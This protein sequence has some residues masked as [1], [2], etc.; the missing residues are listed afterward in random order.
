MRND[1]SAKKNECF[2]GRFKS[3]Y[4]YPQAHRDFRTDLDFKTVGTTAM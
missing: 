3:D 4:S 2:G 1:G